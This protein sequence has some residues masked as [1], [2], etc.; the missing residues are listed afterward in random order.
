M[1][2]LTAQAQAHLP[3][4]AALP[5]LTDAERAMAVRTW[6]GRMV[7]EYVSAGVWT[8][9]TRQLLDAGAA[10][11]L[12]V[13][14]ATAT[15][16][17]LRHAAQCAAVVVA[18]GGEA[19]APLPALDEVPAHEDAGRIEAVLRN[20]VS[21]GCMSETIAVSII[22]AEH[23]ELAAGPLADTL[24]G[25]LADEIQH[26][27]LGWRALGVLLPHLDSAAKARLDRYLIDAFAHQVAYEV[28]KL[29]VLGAVRDELAQA[30]VCDGGFARQ[31]FLDTIEQVIV[32]GLAGAGLAAHD[33]WTTARSHTRHYFQEV[34]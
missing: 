29:P 34:A 25:I 31:L 32:P 6:R 33:A 4:L 15:T 9:I 26:A 8:V 5:A 16:D 30:G 10:P 14:S 11:D 3:D 18:L 20:L 23:A 17:E 12:V 2:D 1:L 28:P 13:A 21:V 27:R 7:N 24:Q 19:V 22:R